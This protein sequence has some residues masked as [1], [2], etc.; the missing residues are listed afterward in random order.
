MNNISIGKRLAIGFGLILGL[1]ILLSIQIRS[2]L[3]GLQGDIVRNLAQRSA[4]AAKNTADMIGESVRNADDGVQIA[5]ASQEQSVGLQQVNSAVSDMDKITQQNAANA[6]ESASASE[7]LSSQSEELQAM[8]SQF[9]VSGGGVM[10]STTPS[11]LPK[12][13]HGHW[14]AGKNAPVKHKIPKVQ[15]IVA[16]EIIPLDNEY[17]K[18]F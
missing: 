11:H 12:L 9:K 8:V 1:V 13:T 5:S 4:Q 6:E 10:A 7:E 15:K 18:E 16:E 3:V 2:T 17:L 14:H